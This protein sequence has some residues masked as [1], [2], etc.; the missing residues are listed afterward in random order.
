MTSLFP[1]AATLLFSI[2]TQRFP[3]PGMCHFISVQQDPCDGGLIAK[4]RDGKT[5]ALKCKLLIQI[6]V[7]GER[8]AQDL[9]PARLS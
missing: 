4:P 6:H 9:H 1:E 2:L 3:V 8:Q 5:E 7:A